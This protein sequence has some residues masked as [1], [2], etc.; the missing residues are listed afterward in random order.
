MA[1]RS[2]TFEYRGVD[3]AVLDVRA[4]GRLDFET[5][6]NGV[7]IIRSWHVR[8]PKLRYLP[9]GRFVRRRFVVDGAVADAEELHETGGL[10]AAGQ[11]ADGTAIASPL[12]ALSGRVLNARTD[13]TVPGAVVTLDSTDLS[14]VADARGQFSFEYVLPGPYTI[15]VRDSVA[16]H[17]VTVDSVGN[18]I[19]D[20][21]VQQVVRRVATMPV[22]ARLGRVD[23]VDVSLPWRASVGG[24]GAVEEVERRYVVMGV[25]LT[26]DTMPIPNANIRLSWSATSR[27]A[28]LETIVD[29]VADEGGG[30]FMCGIPAG[31]PLRTH[32]TTPAGAEHDGTTTVNR[33]DYDEQGRRRE[34][35]LRAIRLVVSPP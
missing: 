3:Q 17:Q 15:R 27:G 24:C 25:V 10:I 11:L 33:I 31:I 20:S 23:P 29:A 35:T 14:V 13:E 9:S 21:S 5:M 7:P 16:I 28:T 8:S 2:M 32:I 22:E 30:F 6:S 34:G 4:G 1:L 12:A 19:P 26:S 18:I